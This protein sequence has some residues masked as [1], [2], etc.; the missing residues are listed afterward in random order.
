MKTKRKNRA[1]LMQIS[2]IV[3]KM[4]KAAPTHKKTGTTVINQNG[5][6]YVFNYKRKKAD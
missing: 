5:K 1:N 2:G 3:D 6:V 4:L